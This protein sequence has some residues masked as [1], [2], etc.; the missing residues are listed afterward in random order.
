MKIVIDKEFE[1]RADLDQYVRVTFGDNT[2]ANKDVS[3]E[4]DIA[5]MQ[6]LQLSESTKVHGVKVKQ[7]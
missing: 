7:A 6:K 3:M 1:T 4:M 2:E 5:T